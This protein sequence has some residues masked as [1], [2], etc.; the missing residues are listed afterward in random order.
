MD[1]TFSPEIENALRCA[2]LYF[3]V[4]DNRPWF[5]HR[6]FNT[7]K[8]RSWQEEVAD[9]AEYIRFMTEHGVMMPSNRRTL[10]DIALPKLEK[11]L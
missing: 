7:K 11:W 3:E 5:W 2:N 8:W 9:T 4:M 1:F 6:W 10:K